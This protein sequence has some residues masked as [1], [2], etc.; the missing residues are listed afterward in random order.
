MKQVGRVTGHQF[1]FVYIG[2]VPYNPA[3]VKRFIDKGAGIKLQDLVIFEAGEDR[4]L[5]FIKNAKYMDTVE[6]KR[7]VKEFVRASEL[8]Y[9][10]MGDFSEC[11]DAIKKELAEEGIVI[12]NEGVFKTPAIPEDP[13]SF[14]FGAPVVPFSRASDFDPALLAA[15]HSEQRR[16]L[17]ILL[18]S[19]LKVASDIAQGS[20]EVDLNVLKQDALELAEW[21]DNN[22]TG[23]L[24]ETRRFLEK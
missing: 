4:V 17:S 11:S 24:R 19:S 7:M 21:V 9:A 8:E 12:T 5:D 10:K 15:M 23:I 22:S 2:G 6:E 3:K 16:T 1:G 13:E 20:S 14:D 18:Q